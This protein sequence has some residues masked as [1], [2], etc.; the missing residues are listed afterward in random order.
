MHYSR[1][2][3]VFKAITGNIANTIIQSDR[4]GNIHNINH[5]Q[6]G[7]SKEHILSSTVF[8]FVPKEQWPVIEKALNDVFELGEIR[9]YETDGPGPNNE[10]RTYSV[11]VS[12]IFAND[13]VKS[14]IFLA[15]DTTEHKKALEEL[16]KSEIKY[17]TL[18]EVL[19][20]GIT[21]SDDTG[22]ILDSNKRSK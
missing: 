17:K 3:I 22:N 7:F 21:I 9:K 13:T 8:D 11:T 6:P 20:I 19:P 1:A 5:V 15:E 4:S 12:P 14:A 18:F 16:H 10:I 2:R